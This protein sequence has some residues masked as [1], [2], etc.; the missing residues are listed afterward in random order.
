MCVYVSVCIVY[1]VCVCVCACMLVCILCTVCV[2][3]TALF[4]IFKPHKVALYLF[5]LLSVDLP[6]KF[7]KSQ[8][9]AEDD[10]IVR[11]NMLTS[12][13]TDNVELALT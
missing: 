13:K 3:C 1:C 5:H 4:P 11:P 7:H 6:Y 8:N 10:P 12:H 2:V 9:H